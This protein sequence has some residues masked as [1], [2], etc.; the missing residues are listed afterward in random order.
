M[1]EKNANEILR[2]IREVHIRI[3]ALLQ[4]MASKVSLSEC[5][6]CTNVCCRE[7]ICRESVESEFLR[8]ILGSQIAD[9]RED[10]GWFEVGVGCRTAFGR[11]LVCYEYFCSIFRTDEKALEL[12]K[13]SKEFVETYAKVIGQKHML[14]IDNIHVVSEAKLLKILQKLQSFEIK[15]Q[16]QLAVRPAP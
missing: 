6:K 1:P 11:P 10:E 7:S 12:E 5:A 3:E 13:L 16:G 9:Y 8:F 2:E 15:A 14:E 4:A